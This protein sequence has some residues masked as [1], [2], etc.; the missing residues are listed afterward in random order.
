MTEPLGVICKVLSFDHVSMRYL[1]SARV[2]ILCD[3]CVVGSYALSCMMLPIVMG[4]ASLW[5]VDL[6][7]MSKSM[8]WLLLAFLFGLLHLDLAVSWIRGVSSS[9]QSVSFTTIVTSS[10]VA[11]D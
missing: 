5:S 1:T 3:P 11:L 9:S 7:S 10:L 4:S 2:P 6:T 8:S